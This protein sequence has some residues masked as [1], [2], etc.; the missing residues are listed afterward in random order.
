[1]VRSL[2]AVLALLMATAVATAAERKALKDVDF[3]QFTRDSQRQIGGDRQMTLVWWIPVEFWEASEAKQRGSTEA[4]Q[5]SAMVEALRPYILVGIVKAD[6]SEL[7]GFKFAGREAISDGLR[8][9]YE[10]AG[11]EAIRLVSV[12][13][14]DPDLN[15]VLGALRPV[16][17]NAIGPMGQNMHFYTLTDSIEDGVT[18]VS[19]YEPGQ[20]VVEL[21]GEG[22]SGPD[23][24]VIDTPMDSLFVPREC[25]G[26]K[27]AHISWK[28]CPWD[29]TPLK[30]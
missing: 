20:M 6:I 12:E 25:P 11:K 17:V 2:T 14:E 18:P 19:P 9:R 29:G 22:D 10:S 4:D 26:G 27:V 3:G 5:G 16:L 13:A 24:V 28:V 30:P 15:I 1:M 7:G 21:K 8:V 23:Q